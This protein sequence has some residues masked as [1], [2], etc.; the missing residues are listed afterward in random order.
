M[1]TAFNVAASAMAFADG[2]AAIGTG[3]EA[4][5]H[6]YLVAQL[7]LTLILARSS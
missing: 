2:C 3:F 4:C 6:E 1:R 7:R 5:A